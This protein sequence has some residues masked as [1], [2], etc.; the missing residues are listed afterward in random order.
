M[1]TWVID[2]AFFQ[3][4]LWVASIIIITLYCEVP[5]TNIDLA[6]YEIKYYNYIIRKLKKI[7]K[8]LVMIII[9]YYYI[10]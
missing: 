8:I 1:T 2:N 9:N 10:T 5:Q 4:Y 6:L 3:Y 7:L